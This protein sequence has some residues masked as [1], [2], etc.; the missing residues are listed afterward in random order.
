M[1]ASA[2][3][4]PWAVF[5]ERSFLLGSSR[6][7]EPDPERVCGLAGERTT[8]GP[9]PAGTEQLSPGRKALE[10]LRVRLRLHRGVTSGAGGSLLWEPQRSRG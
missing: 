9:G 10:V 6:N 4:T 7:R 1:Q 5:G 8:A 3:R 2:H